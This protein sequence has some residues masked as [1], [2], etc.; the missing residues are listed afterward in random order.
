M[1]LIDKVEKADVKLE[2]DFATEIMYMD[3]L[4]AQTRAYAL[5]HAGRNLQEGTKDFDRAV[6]ALGRYKKLMKMFAEAIGGA[7]VTVTPG[8]VLWKPEGEKVF[9]AYTVTF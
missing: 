8:R 5:G 7:V 1:A 9:K 2:L 4:M 6:H 3:V